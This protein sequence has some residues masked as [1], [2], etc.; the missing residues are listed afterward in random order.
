MAD[1]SCLWRKADGQVKSAL[2]RPSAKSPP[3]CLFQK[4]FWRSLLMK[5][6]HDSFAGSSYFRHRR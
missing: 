1:F 2:T 4:A 5:T 6:A 3:E